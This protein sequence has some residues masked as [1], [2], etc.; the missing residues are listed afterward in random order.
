MWLPRASGP[1]SRGGPM[2]CAHRRGF[3]LPRTHCHSCVGTGTQ[4]WVLPYKTGCCYGAVCFG[5]QDV[6]LVPRPVQSRWNR[7]AVGA[8]GSSRCSWWVLFFSCVFGCF[9]GEMDNRRGV[10]VVDICPFAG[11]LCLWLF[12]ICQFWGINAP[13]ELLG[14]VWRSP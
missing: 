4:L 5:D 8:G 1:Y 14:D 12:Y 13:V 7:V 6:I 9:D 3:S 2:S 11:F 10:L